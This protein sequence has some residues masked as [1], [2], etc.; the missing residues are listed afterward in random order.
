MRADAGYFTVEL[1]HAAVEHGCDFAIAAKRNTAMWR[2]Y[3]GIG[4]DAWVDAHGHARR[5]GRRGRLRPGRLAR[6]QLHHRAAGPHRR[7]G[8]L[9][10][11][12]IPAAAHH[13]PRPARA[14]VGRHRDPRLRGLAS[15]SPTSPPTT[16]PTRATAS[17]QTVRDVEAWF[18][19]RTDIED[20][21]RE[22]KLGAGLRHLPSA[23]TAVNAVWMWAALLAGNLSVLLQALTG[24]DEHGRAHAARLRHEL[25]CVPAR[26]IR[27][28]RAP[29]PAT[30]TRPP[31][32]AQRARQDPSNSTPRPDAAVPPR[33]PGPSE[34]RH[35][36][37]HRAHRRARDHLPHP[38]TP[39]P[40]SRSDRG[41]D[42]SP[43]RGSGS[44]P[45]VPLVA[46][47]GSSKP[48]GRFRR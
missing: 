32:A 2:A 17:G 38:N 24:I 46:A 45:Y 15:S 41:Q 1:A 6:G 9:R 31:P 23:H 25:L 39:Q 18:R 47:Y 8:H 14:G 48:Q 37:R 5:A 22:A 28:G 12:A 43:T 21:I 19:R 44:E 42:S 16:S 36:G 30:A 29:D 26:L 40:G 7:R 3:A 33:R 13:R 34:Q 10:R 20:R 35:P 27:H 4:E 11:P